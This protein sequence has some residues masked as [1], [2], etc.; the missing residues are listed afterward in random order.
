MTLEQ[1]CKKLLVKEP[2]Y[3]LFLLGLNKYYGN[4]CP[5]ACVCRNGINTELCIN[6]E[7]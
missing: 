4:K 6:Q 7:F 5:T 1:A 2:F 3:G